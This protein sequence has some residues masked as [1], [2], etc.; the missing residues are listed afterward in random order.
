MKKRL[1]AAILLL[2]T[3][4]FTALFS[5]PVYAAQ[6]ESNV[7]SEEKQEISDEVRELMVKAENG[8]AKA[9][10]SLGHAYDFGKG[11]QQDYEKA[12]EW[13][14]RSAEQG[15]AKAQYNLGCMYHYGDGVKQDYEKAVE[16][17]TK[18][19]EPGIYVSIWLWSRAGLQKSR[20]MVY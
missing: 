14:A 3:V 13:Y 16:W 19:A 7:Q 20:R 10:F 9:Q 8:D 12:A 17:Y 18:S 1:T 15:Y 2:T 5:R 4:L 11:I 6:E